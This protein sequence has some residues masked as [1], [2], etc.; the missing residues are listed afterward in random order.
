M[1]DLDYFHPAVKDWFNRQFNAATSAQLAAWPSI[2]QHQPTLI[3]APTGSGKTLAAFLAAIDDLVREGLNEGLKDNTH[4]LYVSPLKALSNDI[5]KNLQQPLNGIRDSLLENGYPDVAIR[6]QVR[7]GDTSQAE[8][9]QMK[10]TPPHILVTTPESLY[11]LLTSDSGR[12]ILSTVR[13][14]IV[15]EIHALAGN[16]RGAHL[17]LSLARLDTICPSPPNRIGLSATQKPI[18]NIADYLCGISKLREHCNI[19]DTGHKRQRDLAIQLTG[20]PLQAVMANETWCEIYDQLEQLIEQHSTTLIFVNTRRLAERAAHHLA[21]R[22]GEEFVTAHHGSLSKEHRLHAEQRLKAGKLKALVATASLELGIDIG[23]IDLVCQLGSPGSIAAF[24][25]RVGRSGHAVGALPKGRIFPLSRDDLLESVAL[26]DAIEQG[27]L[28]TITIPDAP[29]DVLSQQLVAEIAS[30]EW[31][32]QEL[33]NTFKSAWPYRDLQPHQYQQIIKMLSEGFTLKRG[34]RGAYLHHD[35]INKK[36]RGRRGAK[37][38]AVLNGGAIPDQFDYDVIMQPQGHFVGTLNEDFAFESL[39]GDIFQLGNTSYRMLKIENGRVFVEDA[40][41]E[42]PTIPFWFGEAPGRTNELSRA[43]SDFRDQ[44]SQQL[45][46]GLE[47]TISWLKERY[48]LDD[49]AATQLAEYLA[50]SKA[51]LGTLPTQDTIVFE[52]FLDETGDMHLVIHSPFGSR[53]NRAWGLALRKR[54]CRKFNFE[55]QAAANEDNI[56]I[57]LGATHSFPLEEVAHYLN[58]NNAK[59]ILTQALLDAPM[60]PTHWRWNANIALA[61]PRNRNGKKV[62]AYFQRNDAEDLIALV[63]PDQIACFENLQGDRE[64]PDHPLVKQAINDCL[65]DIMDADGLV[66]LLT[67]IKSNDVNIVCRDLNAPSPMSQEVINSK[68]YAFL[69]DTPAEERRTLAIQQQAHLSPQ[70]AAELGRLNPDAITKVKQQAWPDPQSADELHDALMLLG[71]LTENEMQDFNQAYLKKLLSEN[72]IVKC[73]TRDEVTTSLWIA[74]ERASQFKLLFDNASFVPELMIPPIEPV[75]D[76]DKALV[77]IIR[78]RLEGLGPV[79]AAQLANPLAIEVQYIQNALLA[80][81]Q[82]GYVIRGQFSS[83]IN[84]QEQWCE[85]GLLARIHR[86]TLQTLRAEIKPVS[87]AAYIRFLLNWHQLD[88]KRDGK[89]ALHSII[90]QLEGFPIPARSW[91]TEIFPGR[92]EFYLPDWLDQL[93]VSGRL[94]WLRLLKQKATPP[95]RPKQSTPIRNTPICL[96]SRNATQYWLQTVNRQDD[97]Q[98]KNTNKSLLNPNAS[99]IRHLLLDKGACFFDD[100]VASTHLLRTQVETALGELVNQGIVTSDNF[101][102]IR[103]LVTPS[104]RR[105]K[106]GA[107]RNLSSASF[108][109]EDAG[110]WSIVQNRQPD[111]EEQHNLDIRIEH[112]ARVLLKRYG[113]VFRKVLDRETNI[114]SWRELLY[115]FR[116][117]EAR[118][119]IRGGRFVDGFPGEQFALPD[120]VSA[121]R[122]FREPPR[123]QQLVSVS[124]T[125][126]LNLVGIITPGERISAVARQKVLYCNGEPIA[127]SS[128]NEVTFVKQVDQHLEWNAREH[129]MRTRQTSRV[130][131][132]H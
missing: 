23:D 25:Q 3:A 34:R 53:V 126:P 69:D 43:V 28:D 37:L 5:Q 61:V 76:K 74:A 89:D 132:R 10:K 22:I 63:F 41:G 55:L 1:T 18:E 42:P 100:I 128:G 116:R 71:F 54:F 88:E 81:E 39:P 101:A 46:R 80:L 60:F 56:V 48:Q 82:E 57:S 51:A 112:I 47:S 35:A 109:I 38:V 13:S 2:K 58:P 78:S 49:S 52:R 120:A 72:R 94:S 98:N 90:E 129:L 122:K 68:P 127:R 45:D 44:A 36:L 6:A 113:V 40:H 91:E 14:V 107:R 85:R 103:A 119:E 8:R 11:I 27:E 59:D 92:L 83:D 104:N 9:Q 95:D 26:I 29:L 130:D 12:Q 4:I 30:R 33:L 106:F 115:V 123:E 32:E 117:L 66:E 97:K 17:S 16:K 84:A 19:I 102:G 108:S 15:D 118:G 93:C 20:T 24:L 70:A 111:K 65:Y 67:R 124:A 86:Y 125:D 99:A 21:E 87:P 50:A 77:E 79:S 31:N 64:I 114:P 105:P 62:P 96:V 121:L 131:V 110:R 73:K 7:T 75:M